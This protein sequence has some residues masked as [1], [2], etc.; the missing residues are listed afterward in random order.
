MLKFTLTEKV[1][2]S[3]RTVVKKPVLASGKIPKARRAYNTWVANETLE[4]Y[5]LRYTPSSFRKWSEY[6]VANTAIG[7]IS[8]LALEAIG[9][10]IAISYGFT[11]AFWGI[12]V[13]SAIIFLTG[14][15]IAYYASKYNIDMDLL[16]RG[17]GFG[18]IG[19]TITSL[20]YA[21][22]TF[23]FFALE[24]AI[25]SQALELY[26]H[27]PLPIGY[28]L[29][30]IIIIPM[31]VFGITFISQLQLWT[32][33]IW[34]TLTI[35]PYICVLCKQPEQW[36]NW[37]NFAGNSPSGAGF[38][39][40]LFGAAASVS[41][42]LIAQIGE[43][44]DYLRFMPDEKPNNQTKWWMAVISS[45]P[46]WIFIGAAKQLGGSFLTALA[47]SLGIGITEANEPSLMY[48][49]GFQAVFSNPEI[50]LFVSTFFVILSQIKI[51]VTNAY[52]GSLAWS[53]FFSRLTHAHP[54]RVV[55]LVFNIAIALL[56]MELG[57][58]HT[59]EKVLGFYANV[60]LAW[61]GALVADLVVNKPLGISPPYIEFKRAY[62]YNINPVGFGSMVI[63]S[64]VSIIAFFGGL[65]P[66]AKA[67]APFIALGLAFLLA[68]A[69][70]FITKGKYYIAREDNF[71]NS[72]DV[73]A[74]TCSICEYEYYKEDMAY[75][76]IYDG[77]ICSLC[78]TLD[79]R[80]H[81]SCKS[82]RG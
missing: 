12:I 69:I 35:A 34:V 2:K 19:S 57:I 51:N 15:P 27:L 48:L 55:W 24:A 36:S 23:I 25:M 9:G 49:S 67:F 52:A 18:Y 42:S 58:F 65:G 3:S 38:D 80:C 82:D 68:P 43:Q 22:F 54:G 76:P 44:V 32:Q 59:L 28:I 74:I 71:R 33:P 66:I 29:S 47:V 60:A 64:L 4:D 45:G 81:D 20:I 7:G 75:C 63:A 26:F 41:L 31:V 5:A 50:I 73:K 8:F 21:S 6:I 10:S 30:S 79:A 37:L 13:A 14:I 1:L 16:T 17:A 70:A 56:L 11:N 53:N 72:L 77:P 61:I 39:P 78:C 40:I 62:L 46:G